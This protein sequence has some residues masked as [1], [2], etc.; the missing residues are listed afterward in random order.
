M[1][2]MKGGVTN[3]GSNAGGGIGYCN[4]IF[5]QNQHICMQTDGV[6]STLSISCKNRG[7]KNVSSFFLLCP[8]RSSFFLPLLLLFPPQGGPFGHFFSPGAAVLNS[9]WGAKKRLPARPFV[10]NNLI[11]LKAGA[12]AKTPTFAPRKS[13]VCPKSRFPDA[14]FR[15]PVSSLQS[16]RSVTN[17]R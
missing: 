1:R 15:L 14:G 2:L 5:N 10:H 7:H 8:P 6:F 13:G 3:K 12:K 11:I 16:R 9:L 4:F 17:K